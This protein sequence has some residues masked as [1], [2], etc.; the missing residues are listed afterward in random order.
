MTTYSVSGRSALVTGAAR[1]IGFETARL[2]HERGA[3]VTLVD[4]DPAATEEAA[5]RIGP[6]ATAIAADVTDTDAIAAAIDETAER[7]ERLDIVVANAGVAPPVM[8]MRVVDA[9]AFERVVEIDLL[10]VWRTV[11]PAL[12]H[13]VPS[14]GQ[15]VVVA[16]VYAFVN[17]AVAAPYA[18]SKA[19]VEQLGR[20][21]RSEL[22]HTGAT[23]TVAYFG[24]ID[25]DMVRDAFADPLAARF[26]ATFPGFMTRRLTAA[27]AGGGIVD[28]IEKRAR[29]VILPKWW[30]A[31]S[32]LRGV[33]NPILDRAMTRND[34]LTDVLR[35][36]D[37]PE[38]E[39]L[40][41]DA[42]REDRGVA[43]RVEAHGG[44]RDPGRHLG[45][46]E[47]RVHPAEG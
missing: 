27:D 37:R 12:A 2:L 6:R 38:R 8:T 42:S 25:T 29:T 7:N 41:D 39:L 46:R 10:G 47:Q 44:D 26:E 32:A 33:V 36:A 4:L 28:G 11:K 31:Y 15:V 23:A 30:R 16:S 5:E 22:H 13:V 20:A 17:G 35:E 3:S 24:F 18:V 43:G 21:L 45:A 14:Q 19:G 9:D 34:E 1:G 40:A